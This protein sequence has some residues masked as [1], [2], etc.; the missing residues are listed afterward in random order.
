MFK[1]HHYKALPSWAEA[2][3][4]EGKGHGLF[5]NVDIPAGSYLGVTHLA[6]AEQQVEH[7]GRNYVRTPLGG[8]INHSETP[9]CALLRHPR[10]NKPKELGIVTHMWAILPIKKGSELTCF[11]TDGYEDIIDNFDGPKNLAEL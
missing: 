1:E 3:Q 10:P 11:Y 9:N 5:T 4:V 8:F 6:L 7:I 2:K